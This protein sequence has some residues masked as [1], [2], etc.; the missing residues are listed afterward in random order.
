ML[1]AVCLGTN[2][3]AAAR[4]FYDVVLAELGLAALVAESHEIGYGRPGKRPLL[5]IVI[6][7][8]EEPATF[9]NGTQVMFEARDP[10]QVDAV[11]W[12]M[13]ERGGT[14]E[15]APGPR[16]YAAGY[17]GAYARDLDGNKIHIFYL[18]D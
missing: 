4:A 15:G 1:S 11:H 8:N 2:D 6:P 12:L 17:Y 14:D 18:P 10:A 16:A 13:L 7:F 5:W 9:G 3:L